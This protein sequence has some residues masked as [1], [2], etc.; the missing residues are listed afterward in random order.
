MKRIYII[1]LAVLAVACQ[2]HWDMIPPNGVVPSEQEFE[3]NWYVS[4]EGSGT[5]SGSDWSNAL[6]FN[7]FLTLITTPDVSFVGVGI[8]IK[9]GSYPVTVGE[10]GFLSLT[11]DIPCI[12]GGYSAELTYSDLSVCDPEEYPTV[13]TGEKGFAYVTEAS[14][15]LENITFQDFHENVFYIDGQYLTTSVECDHC[16]FDNNVNGVA[17]TSKAGGSCAYVMQGYFKARN[18]VFKDNSAV[19]R[20]GAIRTNGLSSVLY[21]DRCMFVGNSVSDCWGT[22]IQNTKGVVCANNCTFVNNVGKGSTLNGGGAFFLS[23]CTILEDSFPDEEE[24]NN[25]AFRCESTAYAQTTI[26]NCI[27]GN[28]HPDGYGMVIN[29]GGV[30]KS[31]G[32]NFVKEIKLGDNCEDPCISSDLKKNIVLE[33]ETDLKTYCWKW[34]FDQLSPYFAQKALAD[35]VY[36]TALNFNP[37]SYCAISVLGRSFAIW[38]TPNSFAID[39][40]GELRGDDGFQPGAYDTNLDII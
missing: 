20:G 11:C 24:T 19:S 2:P 28:T 3:V 22:A 9:E 12:R 37:S 15:R 21:L 33:G 34:S 4:L 29:S 7:D 18:C 26:I 16:I 14:V 36:E 35:D 13:F 25:A 27:L 17:T 10:S 8:H 40:R 23:N 1:L 31:K 5:K 32:H 39:C 38:V 30:V 6:P